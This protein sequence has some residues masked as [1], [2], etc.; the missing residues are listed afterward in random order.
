MCRTLLL[1]LPT[2]ASNEESL[3]SKSDIPEFLAR[4]APL[5]F[6]NK[7]REY[8]GLGRGISEQI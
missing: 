5:Q 2:K 8:D 1:L 3:L 6:R 4:V 7:H